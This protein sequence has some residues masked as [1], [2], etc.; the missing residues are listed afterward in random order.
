MVTLTRPRKIA[1]NRRVNTFLNIITEHSPACLGPLGKRLRTLSL[2]QR[3][4]L[5][6]AFD[7]TENQ[8]GMALLTLRFRAGP[9]NCDAGLKLGKRWQHLSNELHCGGC[10]PIKAPAQSSSVHNCAWSEL[11]KGKRHWSSSHPAFS[12]LPRELISTFLGRFVPFS[13]KSGK[14]HRHAS[15]KVTGIRASSEFWYEEEVEF[16]VNEIVRPKRIVL[17]RCAEHNREG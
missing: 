14:V 5:E 16:D 6:N 13:S 8:G 7:P 2:D 11:R 10:W 4:P 1:R 17:M 12:Q 9:L 15:N 3:S